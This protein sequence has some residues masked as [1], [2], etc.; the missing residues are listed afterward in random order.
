MVIILIKK[1]FFNK[2]TLSSGNILNKI[3]A[4]FSQ[5]GVMDDQGNM[6]RKDYLFQ[7]QFLEIIA[8]YNDHVKR[9]FGHYLYPLLY[10]C[11]FGGAA[12]DW[13]M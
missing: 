9:N 13:L 6:Q 12:C 3:T 2:V 10:E 7:D 11:N 8:Q 1:L 5:S 4:C